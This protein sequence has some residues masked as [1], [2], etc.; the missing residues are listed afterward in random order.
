MKPFTA[1]VAGGITAVVISAICAALVA[2]FPIGFVKS[3]GGAVFHGM[4]ISAIMM[5]PQFTVFSLLLGFIYA[6][7]TGFV[8]GG[9]FAWAYN[10]AEKNLK[11]KGR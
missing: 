5:R 9:V 7:I 2:V 8:I 4:N 10:W 3:Y 6:F 11:G 1:A